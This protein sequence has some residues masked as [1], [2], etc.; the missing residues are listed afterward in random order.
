MTDSSFSFE[1]LDAWQDAR[2]FVCGIYKAT[3]SFPQS[4]QFGLTSQIR[5]AA[6]SVASNIAEGTSRFSD[7][8]KARFLE[9]A[10]GSMMEV[11]CQ[12]RLASDLGFLNSEDFSALKS[13]ATLISK[14]L[15]ALRKAYLSRAR[16]AS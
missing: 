10:Y 2:N 9:I 15:S 14:R 7:R 8:D 12:L 1:R 16:S 5:R 4:E 3:E 11:Y 6:V 13:S